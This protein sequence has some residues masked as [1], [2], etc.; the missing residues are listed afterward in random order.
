MMPKDHM[1]HMLL[2]A[3][4]KTKKL[5]IFKMNDQDKSLVLERVY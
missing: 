2:K 5:K 1:D 4:F 3:L